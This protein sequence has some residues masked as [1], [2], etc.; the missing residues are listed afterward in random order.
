M[1]EYLCNDCGHEFY[2]DK[3][4]ENDNKCPNCQSE[5]CDMTY[6]S[7]MIEARKNEKK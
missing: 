7:E 4:V 2:I 1:E 5:N 3:Y 6:D